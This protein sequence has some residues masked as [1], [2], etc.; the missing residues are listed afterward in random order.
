M[1]PS[2]ARPTP[3][4]VPVPSRPISPATTSGSPSPFGSRRSGTP[5]PTAAEEARSVPA[6]SPSRATTTTGERSKSAVLMVAAAV[7]GSASALTV[8]GLPRAGGRQRGRVFVGGGGRRGAPPP[9]RAG[10]GLVGEGC[11]PPCAEDRDER[12]R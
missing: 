7:T 6:R 4:T 1:A 9:L 2:E 11:A 3:S 10:P 8:R 12:D 5:S